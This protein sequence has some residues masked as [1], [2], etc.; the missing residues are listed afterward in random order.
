MPKPSLCCPFTT[1]LG[2]DAEVHT[3]AFV[4]EH[5]RQFS[6]NFNGL[7]MPVIHGPLKRLKTNLYFSGHPPN[8]KRFFPGWHLIAARND[9]S[10][11]AYAMECFGVACCHGS[12]ARSVYIGCGDGNSAY[13]RVFDDVL[14]TDR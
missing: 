7:D 12:R 10:R 9:V 4:G 3:A 11:I 14:F 5:S 1:I 8:T 2:Q 6:I 13:S